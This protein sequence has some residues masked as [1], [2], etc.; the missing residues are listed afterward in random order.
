[1]RRR[2]RPPAARAREAQWTITFTLTSLRVSGVTGSAATTAAR[3]G[4]GGGR[5][6]ASASVRDA[7]TA[8]VREEALSDTGGPAIGVWDAGRAA[9]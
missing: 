5:N 1:M 4:P 6:R 3:A 9:W 7:A 8:C 2:A